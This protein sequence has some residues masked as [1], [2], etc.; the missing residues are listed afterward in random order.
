MDKGTFFRSRIFAV[1]A[2]L[3][4]AAAVLA[5]AGQSTVY[6]AYTV[7][8]VSLPLSES[9][10]RAGDYRGAGLCW[11]FAQHIYY[12]IW[13]RVFSMNAG[14]EDD[15][16]RD[17]PGGEE[18][19]ITAENARR[20]ISAAPL[21]SVIRLQGTTDGPDSVKCNRHSLILLDKTETGCTV[22]H[23]W[24]GYASVD[25]FTW[26]QFEYQFRRTTDFGYFKYIKCPGVEALTLE[27]TGEETEKEMVISSKMNS[28]AVITEKKR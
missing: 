28:V 23:D 5:G 14:S 6:A 2:A 26:T 9:G 24:A 19:R 18:R 15:L 17:Y 3:V 10:Y 22:Y 4:L 11:Q 21:G 20:F 7:E 25:T 8:G 1:A 12:S 16:L 13:N 27:Y